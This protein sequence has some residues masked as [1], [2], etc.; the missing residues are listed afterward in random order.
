MVFNSYTFIV[1]F[2]IILFLHNL[3]LPWKVKK[4]N[5]LIASYIFYAAWN[6]PFI[7]LLWLST[8]VDFFVGRALYTQSNK[9]K[10]RFLLV[11][12][13]IGNLGM[14]CF[15]KYGGFLLENFVQLSNALGFNY[16]PAKPNIILPAGISFYTFTTLCY[17]ID[18]YKRKSE[19]VKSI[20][21]FSL[22]VTFFPH[23]V[24]GPIVRPPQLVPQFETPRKANRQQ[25]IDGLMLLSLGL[26]MKV[27]LADAMLSATADS[28]FGAQSAL[29][30]LDAWTGVLAFSGQ[31]F[32]DFAGYSTSAIGVA[33]CLG[34]I[35]PQNFLYPYAAIGFSDFWRRWHIT[36]SSWLRDYLYIPLGG[37]R[38]GKFK[39]Y[40]NIMITMLIGG[41]WHGANWTFV[42]WGGLHGIYLWIEKA[43]KDSRAKASGFPADG[44]PAPVIAT[45][46]F[47]PNVTGKQSGGFLNA[48]LTFLLIC[49]TLV[50]FRSATFSGAWQILNSMSGYT[51]PAGP[52]LLT[53]IAIIKVAVVIGLMLIFHWLMRNTTVLKAAGKLPWWLTGIVWSVTLVLIILSQET[54]K[55]FIY[56]QF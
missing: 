12:S 38:G 9:H 28:V 14:L 19:P 35:L 5:L 11:I 27:V 40:I 15:F 24:A 4:I 36:L 8:V 3:P 7:L 52:P 48:L 46:S 30:P 37:N 17:T 49:V 39:T 29:G 6:P 20:L 10:R 23:L 16:H 51:P 22:F 18:M 44:V 34:F 13:L 2:A 33:L 31:I 54:S 41:L 56:F 42:A 50:F 25:L 53:T 21:D 47:V 32:F 1:F 55:S 43:I 26:F 45:A